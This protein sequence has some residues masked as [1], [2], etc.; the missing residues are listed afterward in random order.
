MALNYRRE[1][2]GLR[3]VAV[4]AV[5]LH[6]AGFDMFSGG[7]VGV[8]VFFVISGYLI[9]SII[10]FEIRQGDFSLANFYE[11]RVRRIFPALF[12]V[13][14]TC[15]PFA[16]LW[17]LPS[18][19]KEFGQSQVAVSLFVSNV[20]FWL[21]AGYFDT[22][23]ELKP[24]LHTWSLAVEEQFYVFYPVC[25][26]L[27]SKYFRR[28]TLIF[29]VFFGVS[30]LVLAQWTSLANPATAF[31]LLQ[32]R[33]WELLLGALAAALLARRDGNEF[34]R[35]LMEFCS[36]FGLLLIL[37]SVFAYDQATPFPGFFALVPTFG[38]VLIILCAKKDTFVGRFL[39][40]KIL[41]GIGLVSYSAYLWHQPMFAFARH[42]S[43]VELGNTQLALIS[44][45]SLFFAYFS[46]RYV[47]VPFRN[48]NN[49]TSRKIF[50]LG[51]TFSLLFVG[52]GLFLNETDGLV[53]RFES[54]LAGDVGQLEFHQYI[55]SNFLDCEPKVIADK[56][57]TWDAFLR[58]KQSKQGVPDVV[59][60]GDSHA[61][62]LFI[63]LAEAKP[64]LNVAFYILDHEPFVNRPAFS[65]IFNE[66]LNNKKSQHVIITMAYG[67][68]FN[69]DN[70]N[71]DGKDLYEGLFATIKSLKYSGKTVSL[72][73]DIPRYQT[74]PESCK[75][76]TQREEI[77]LLCQ[78]SISEA[79]S[80]ALLYSAILKSLSKE[81][82][83]VYFEID[84]L[85][86]GDSSCGMTKGKFVLY[87]DFHHLNIFGS[88]LVGNYL[89][90]K[91]N[92]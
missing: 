42:R 55:E 13:M 17:L 30:G 64:K 33:S 70:G 48:R 49:F 14:L 81:L 28:W 86:C 52:F 12:L 75:Y 84:K 79:D 45:A 63:G 87:R 20:F 85:L 44:L 41:V 15:I 60:L 62:H 10:L 66:L 92:F 32:T 23:A 8:D 7:F 69:E 3:A 88:K 5:I 11:R 24:L 67:M 73:G 18:D 77:S 39:G 37:Y 36:G 53:S 89:A 35:E 6:H 78:L 47:E 56:A 46:W 59:L 76:A 68:R 40:H 90:Q 27:I 21:Q 71:E 31:Y 22:A 65:V 19:L 9:S 29:I 83:V 91:L 4:L 50:S 2:D 82:D 51:I 72:V 61:E 80:Q 38:A 1:I 26:V 74:D 58:C 34:S 57:L 25:L 54:G 43:L 16:L